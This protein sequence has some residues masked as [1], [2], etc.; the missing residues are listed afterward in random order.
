MG[1][2][3][4]SNPRTLVYKNIVPACSNLSM[5]GI[6]MYKYLI[7]SLLFYLLTA[8]NKRS[9]ILNREKFKLWKDTVHVHNYF[10]NLAQSMNIELIRNKRYKYLCHIL[11][12]N[13]FLVFL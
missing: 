10:Q 4:S 12:I 7:Q 6:N 5:K 11:F 13:E 3:D 9:K 1:K 8:M 2:R